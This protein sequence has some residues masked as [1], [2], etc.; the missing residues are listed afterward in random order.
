MVGIAGFNREQIFAAVKDMYTD[1]ATKPKFTFHF[2]IGMEALGA[3]PDR[4][5]AV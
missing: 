5:R 1:V 4:V 3:I 2:P